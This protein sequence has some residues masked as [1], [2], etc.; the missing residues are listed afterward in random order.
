[1]KGHMRGHIEGEKVAENPDRPL[2]SGHRA[3]S[4]RGRRNAAK[5]Q[6]VKLPQHEAGL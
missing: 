4:H 3:S 5:C 6:T 1:M 2:P